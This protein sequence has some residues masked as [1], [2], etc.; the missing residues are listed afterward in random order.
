MCALAAGTAVPHTGKSGW[1]VGDA[2]GVQPDTRLVGEIA[3]GLN[4]I[5][6]ELLGPVLY[7]DVGIEGR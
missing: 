4:R 3:V 1:L 7:T 6:R 5:G 2:V